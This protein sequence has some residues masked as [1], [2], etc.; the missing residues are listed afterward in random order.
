MVASAPSYHGPWTALNDPHPDDTSRTSYQ[1]QVTSVF[2][3]PHKEDLYIALADRWLP[4]Y[5]ESSEAAIRMHDEAFSPM[6]GHTGAGGDLTEVNTVAG[7]LRV[8][9]TALRGW[10]R[11]H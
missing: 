9:A 3:H 8:A 6:G 1:S 10:C 11:L 4:H 5:S 2:R 7:R